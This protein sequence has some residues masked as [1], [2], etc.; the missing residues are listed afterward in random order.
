MKKQ[1]KQFLI[2]IV[3]LAALAGVYFGV[4]SYNEKQAE[5]EAEAEAEAARRET[6]ALVDA[7]ASEIIGFEFVSGG[8]TLRFELAGE[9]EGASAGE[10]AGES[11]GEGEGEGDAWIY[12]A[13]AALDI[14]EDTVAGMLSDL[15]ALTADEKLD[16]PEDAGEY[17]FDAP[18][19]VISYTTASGTKTLTLGMENPVTG[20]YYVKTSDSDDIYLI[21]ATLAMSFGRTLDEMVTEEA[22][23][24]GAGVQE[25]AGGQADAEGQ[26]TTGVQEGADG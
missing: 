12:P 23:T 3:V 7:Q 10:G 9:S 15:C 25:D 4:G 11:E 24:T 17:G 8:E 13:D 1:R 19:N 20:Q 14:D 18:T 16:D 26:A 5:A 6:I 21:P 22:E 2:L